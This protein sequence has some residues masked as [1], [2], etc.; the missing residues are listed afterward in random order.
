LPDRLLLADL[1]AAVSRRERVN[2]VL[3]EKD[4]HLTRLLAALDQRLGASVLLKGGTLLSKVDLGFVRMSED[5]DLVLAGESSRHG[6]ANAA[7]MEPLRA[8]LGELAPELGAALPFPGGERHERN[9]HVVWMLKYESN[10]GKQ[11]IQVEARIHPVMRATRR[12]ALRQLLQDPLLGD[13]AKASCHAL[14]ADEARAE[15]VRAACQREAARDFYDLQRLMD[16]GA[17]LS[18][19]GF[20]RLVDR[21]LA[22]VGLAPLA[23]QG[24]RVALHGK[25]LRDLE[26]S[27]RRDLPRVLREDAQAFDL[28][29][30]L[31]RFEDLWPHDRARMGRLF[32][33]GRRERD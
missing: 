19:P 28:E 10:L 5:V 9:S 25:R 16:A 14:S 7:R 3:V 29:A 15:K 32:L 12:V 2:P 6:Q 27:I 18:S 13:Y 26:V 11:E 22:E 24:S 21:K 17:D 30:M 23:K 1:C 31:R 20:L 4:F 8:A 33:P